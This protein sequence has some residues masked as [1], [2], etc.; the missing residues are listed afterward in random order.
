MSNLTVKCLALAL[1][2][3]SSPAFADPGSGAVAGDDPWLVS[4]FRQS[5][6]A[7]VVGG[8]VMALTPEAAASLRNQLDAR[9]KQRRGRGSEDPRFSATLSVGRD[10]TGR[11]VITAITVH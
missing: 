1:F 5:E 2:A 4:E 9:D 11:P 10:A 6:Q 3:L 8:D 7:V